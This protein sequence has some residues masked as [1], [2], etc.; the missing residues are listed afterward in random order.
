MASVL[1]VTT[2]AGDMQCNAVITRSIFTQILTKDIFVNIIPDVCFASVIVVPYEKYVKLD[3]V[4][5]VLDCIVQWLCIAIQWG[6]KYA[7]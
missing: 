5:T 7:H 3:R 6:I 4:I 1:G 2:T